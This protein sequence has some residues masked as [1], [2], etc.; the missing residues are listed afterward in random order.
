MSREPEYGERLNEISA[1][2]LILWGEQDQL[3]YVSS[4]HVFDREIPDSEL[5]VY[6]D[7]GHLPMFEKPAQLAADITRFLAALDGSSRRH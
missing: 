3:V 2:A 4:A 5:I 6:E 1:P 7:T